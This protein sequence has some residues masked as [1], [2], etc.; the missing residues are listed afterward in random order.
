MLPYTDFYVFTRSRINL[1]WNRVN[2]PG[3]SR[4]QTVI[5]LPFSRPRVEWMLLGEGGGGIMEGVLLFFLRPRSVVYCFYYYYIAT[6]GHVNGF[7]I[8]VHFRTEAYMYRL[9][10]RGVPRKT[11]TRNES[12]RRVGNFPEKNSARPFQKPSKRIRR[13]RVGWNL[14]TSREPAHNCSKVKSMV[15]PSLKT[16]IV[17]RSPN[18]W[19]EILQTRSSDLSCTRRRRYDLCGF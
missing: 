11:T 15:R 1:L 7:D 8:T 3:V 10:C 2:I 9:R 17:A 5:N 14:L 16:D 4:R 6:C 12:F 18:M 19:G 13:S